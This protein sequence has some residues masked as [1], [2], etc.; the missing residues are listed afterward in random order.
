MLQP[1]SKCL[2]AAMSGARSLRFGVLVDFHGAPGFVGGVADI[3]QRAFGA[4]WPARDAQLAP[5][6]DDLVRKICPA[7]ARDD[8][9]QVLLDFHGLIVP[10]E[11]QPPRNAMHVS[12]DNYA[13]ILPEPGA[14]DHIGRLPSHTRNR[15][16]LVH[17]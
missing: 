6:P 7:L 17:G 3:F 15:E 2:I 10:G 4:F 9:H 16:Q 11:L 12:I 13:L 5:M 14:E 1:A 8:A